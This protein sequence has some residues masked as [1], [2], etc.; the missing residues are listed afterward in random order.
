MA[1]PGARTIGGYAVEGEIGGGGMGVVLLGRQ[2]SL[3]RPAVL[4]KLRRELS[5]LPDVAERF[6]REARAAGAVHHPNVVAVYDCFSF[7]SETYIAL[8]HVD[9]LDLRAVLQRVERLPPRIAGLIALEV[10]RG[11][12]AVHE[13]GTVHR[14]LKPANILIG[15][16]GEVKLTDFGVAL[17]PTS[18]ALTRTG[19]VLGTPQYMSPEQLMGERLEPRSDLF[20]YGSV[21]YEMLTGCKPFALGDEE[22]DAEALLTRMRKE[23]YVA[24]EK[25]A[26]GLPRG[27]G[28]LVRRLL[29]AAP[30]QRV[31][32][33]S[34][35]RRELERQLRPPPPVELRRE[36]ASWL[37]DR[38]V[39]ETRQGET[40]VKVGATTLG[41]FRPARGRLRPLAWIVV[42]VLLGAAGLAWLR[43]EPRALS[44]LAALTGPQP[45]ALLRVDAPQ[46]AQLSVDGSPSLAVLGELSL[47]LEAGRHR[48]VLQDAAGR[49][50]AATLDL[51]PGEVRVLR[52][53]AFEPQP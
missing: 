6:E 32:S 50:H 12:E 7:R 51:G 18:P 9:G 33:A 16:S 20:S 41:R 34:A 1:A 15:R 38:G 35:L 3:D 19:V 52:P 8:E 26:P 27:L 13:R 53:D 40:V 30:R 28:R 17:E 49:E 48:I 25:R 31:P 23:R 10:A 24:P 43:L 29:R 21:L 2:L 22:D 5:A 36:L 47:G 14:D 45:R 39:F 11:L 42:S 4:K 46:G 37:W 44:Q